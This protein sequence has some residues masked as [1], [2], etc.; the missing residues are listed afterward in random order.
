MRWKVYLWQGPELGTTG[1]SSTCDVIWAG[2]DCFNEGY[3]LLLIWKTEI[4]GN[5]VGYYSD[6]WR[7]VFEA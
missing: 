6:V 4:S 5:R 3:V 7:F 2:R 1:T